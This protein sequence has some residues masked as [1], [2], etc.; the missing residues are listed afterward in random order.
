MHET[1]LSLGRDT[2]PKYIKSQKQRLVSVS[3]SDFTTRIPRFRNDSTRFIAF[4][5]RLYP[6]RE[7]GCATTDAPATREVF[8]GFVCESV[9]PEVDDSTLSLFSTQH[10]PIST[11]DARAIFMAVP[12]RLWLHHPQNSSTIK[13]GPAIH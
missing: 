2:H 11:N 6:R 9:I 4:P 1:A 3:R 12:S 8:R 7:Y 5:R 10:S 13:R